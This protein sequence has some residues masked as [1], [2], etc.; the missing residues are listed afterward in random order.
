MEIATDNIPPQVHQLFEQLRPHID[1]LNT[2]SGAAL[3]TSDL[4]ALIESGRRYPHLIG[5]SA[6]L[7]AWLLA[8]SNEQAKTGAKR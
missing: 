1:D 4:C 2:I 3:H 6:C 8:R 5:S 7:V